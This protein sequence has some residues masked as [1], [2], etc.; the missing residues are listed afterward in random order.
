MDQGEVVDL[1]VIGAA[2]DDPVAGPEGKGFGTA[3]RL[4]YQIK[5]PSP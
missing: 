1:V 4:F 2:F 5:E 3:I